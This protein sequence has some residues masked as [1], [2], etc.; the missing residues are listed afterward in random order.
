MYILPEVF[1]MNTLYIAFA[2]PLTF[3]TKSSLS[4]DLPLQLAFYDGLLGG[5]SH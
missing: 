4:A 1:K 5:I 2:Q 3:T